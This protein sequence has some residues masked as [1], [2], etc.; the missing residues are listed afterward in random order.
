MAMSAY[1]FALNCYFKQN[2]ARAVGYS[3]TICGIGPIIMPQIFSFLITRFGTTGAVIVISG[4]AV[5]LYVSALLL[6]PIKWHMKKRVIEE[7][8]E[9]NK[10]LETSNFLR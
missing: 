8:D 2:R 6:Q 10:L 3:M 4:I 5:H 1:S 7:V 9:D